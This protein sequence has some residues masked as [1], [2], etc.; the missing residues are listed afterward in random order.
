M[1]AGILDN[2][3][4]RCAAV[5]LFFMGISL[6]GGWFV[7]R[8]NLHMFPPRKTLADILSKNG[9]RLAD[10]HNQSGK[11]IASF[12]P[13]SPAAYRAMD[14]PSQFGWW[15]SEPITK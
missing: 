3:V 11:R 9:F 7:L 14:W 2:A 4:Y 15:A 8:V 1:L 12:K 5:N 10:F 6:S 13:I